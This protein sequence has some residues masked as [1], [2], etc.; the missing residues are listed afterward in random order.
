MESSTSEK[1]S[2]VLLILLCIG[3]IGV[4]IALMALGISKINNNKI[5]GISLISFSCLLLI[6]ILIKLICEI[7]KFIKLSNTLKQTQDGECSVSIKI[8]DFDYNNGNA[9]SDFNISKRKLRR[10]KFSHLNSQGFNYEYS[11]GEKLD[12]IE[13]ENR[14]GG[15]INPEKIKLAILIAIGLIAMSV[16][17]ILLYV[18]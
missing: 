8:K 7:V 3:L 16:A 12:R 10:V 15:M 17:T 13:H 4:L 9:E 11:N 5:I 6:F 2:F 14:K 18:L 1:K